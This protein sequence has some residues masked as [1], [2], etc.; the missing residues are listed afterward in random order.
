MTEGRMPGATNAGT[1]GPP[2][3][4]LGALVGM[5]TV[6][7]FV[8]IHEIFIVD[9]WDS[10]RRMVI[11]GAVC[12]LCLVWSYDKAVTDHS[13][14]RWFGYNAS[15]A[16]LLVALGAVSF[17]VLEPRFTMAELMVSDDALA[18]LIPPALPLM[19]V[20]AVAGSFLLWVLY[21]R[22]RAALIPIVVTQTLLVILVGH[23]LAILGVVEMSA[24]LLYVVGEF[25][26]LTVSL[27]LGFAAGVMLI[28]SVRSWAAARA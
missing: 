21:G 19:I 11:A 23:N 9:I 13:T 28:G 15:Y 12:G 14:R 25:V 16:A 17:V 5:L 2:S 6:L 24:D 1:W 20:A 22:R 4:V 3:K 8:V 27:A 26:V 18:Q 7:G 10:L